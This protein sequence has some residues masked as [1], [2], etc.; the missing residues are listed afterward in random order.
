MNEL[1]KEIDTLERYNPKLVAKLA[2]KADIKA[3]NT[4]TDKEKAEIYK[5]DELYKDLNN[6]RMQS[7]MNYGTI[8]PNSDKLRKEYEIVNDYKR[9]QNKLVTDE[10][11]GL[12]KPIDPELFKGQPPKKPI[13]IP[14]VHLHGNSEDSI[15]ECFGGVG[16]ANLGSAVQYLGN[17][18]KQTKKKQI[19]DEKESL[20]EAFDFGVQLIPYQNND[21]IPTNAVKKFIAWFGK[22]YPYIKQGQYK[23]KVSGELEKLPN[24]W[25]EGIRN[26]ANKINS[27]KDS[28][29]RTR[30]AHGEWPQAVRECIENII[31][32]GASKLFDSKKAAELNI[33]TIEQAEDIITKTFEKNNP[34]VPLKEI[35]DY[36]TKKVGGNFENHLYQNE[37][38]TIRFLD[39][40]PKLIAKGNANSLFN[41][42][43]KFK[44]EWGTKIATDA[45]LGSAIKRN[46]DLFDKWLNHEDVDTLSK[47]D[48]SY[49]NM[50]KKMNPNL[51]D[52]QAKELLAKI[53][54][55]KESAQLGIFESA[56]NYPW[57]SKIM[58]QRLVEDD[59]PADFATGSPI[60]SDMASVG[61]TGGVDTGMAGAD[62][63][64]DG[65]ADIPTM[66]FAGEAQ[67]GG[68]GDVDISV[69]GGDYS[70]EGDEQQMP[71]PNM[72]S[73]KIIDVLA[74]EDDPTDIKVKVQN[75][76][77]KEVEIKNL[78]EIDV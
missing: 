13:E 29:I 12:F 50:L 73:Y 36:L 15:D 51:S 20:D 61:D 9:K 17:K 71:M 60:A 30:G 52:E 1:Q 24:G 27:F 78:D 34:G 10:Y 74:N 57:L 70:P 43:T 7:L 26:N 42:F 39:I 48:L 11:R 18:K 8:Y 63:G 54:Q 6:M 69:G 47:E 40:E 45:K 72:P 46:F 49:L 31:K 16:V 21:Y 68:F 4:L 33:T 37:N 53:R 67:Q 3:D 76:D 66:D 41:P 44:N 35:E 55:Q 59:S 38:D 5:L 58:G 19:E 28:L 65:G 23:D 75:E 56:K 64:M 25:E 22:N 32:V 77:T 2:T 62:T 14:L